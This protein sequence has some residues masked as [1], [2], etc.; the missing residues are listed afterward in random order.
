M[1][2]FMTEKDYMGSLLVKGIRRDPQAD[3]DDE[4]E[5]DQQDSDNITEE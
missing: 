3:S 1:T 5:D 4:E 2:A